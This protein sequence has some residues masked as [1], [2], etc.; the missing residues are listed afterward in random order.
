ML[1]NLNDKN[2][3]ATY[4]WYDESQMMI[5]ENL[6]QKQYDI[7]YW[8]FGNDIIIAWL[9]KKTYRAFDMIHFVPREYWKK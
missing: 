1:Y 2:Y 6:F 3:L 5:E 4:I 8:L 9:P 7:I